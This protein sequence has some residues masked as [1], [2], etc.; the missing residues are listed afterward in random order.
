MSLAT[1]KAT[2]AACAEMALENAEV[3]PVLSLV[4]RAVTQAPTGSPLSR[5]KLIDA[6]PLAP[7]VT[8]VEPTKVCPWPKPEGSSTWLL[9]NWIKN[10]VFGD[11]RERALDVAF[12]AAAGCP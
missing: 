12:R 5:L 11:A 2:L 1:E 6:L 3:S 7:V 8:V 10:V 9:K 4:A